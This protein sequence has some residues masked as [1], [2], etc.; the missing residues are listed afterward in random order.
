MTWREQL[1][2]AKFKGVS[3]KVDTTDHEGGQR[4]ALHEYPLKNGVFPEALGLRGDQFSVRAFLIG[5]NYIADRNALIAKMKESTPGTLV[6]PTLGAKTVQGLNFRSGYDSS[7]GGIEYLDL[8]FI[9]AGFVRFPTKTVDTGS[10]VQSSATQSV[11]SLT[12]AFSNKFNVAGTQGFVSSAAQNLVTKAVSAIWNSAL[13]RSGIPTAL[14]NIQTTLASFQAQIPSVILNPVMMAQG[15]AGLVAQV[16]NVYAV[17]IDAYVA[18]KNLLSFGSSAPSIQA[19]TPQ[20]VQQAS[21]QQAII[22]LTNRTALVGMALA[23]S[24]MTFPSYDDAVALRDD[25]ADR[26]DAELILIG[27]SNDD[28]AYDDFNTLRAAMVQDITTRAANLARI[29]SITLNRSIPA[30]ALSYRLYQSTDQA[31]DIVSR[32]QIQNPGFVPAGQP[33]QILVS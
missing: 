17:P 1:R 28:A 30:L 11:S 13:S 18:Y 16:L 26:M 4:V 5:D 31:D 29:R 8:S 6:L 24:Q 3:F 23:S 21:N 12:A 14:G 20:T 2:K 33:L 9:E 19:T 27:N 15:L 7:L 32:N 22:S 10:L 25:L